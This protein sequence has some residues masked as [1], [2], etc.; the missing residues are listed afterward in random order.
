LANEKDWEWVKIDKKDC[1][2]FAQN[3]PNDIS[4]A[5]WMGGCKD[6]FNC[7]SIEGMVFKLTAPYLP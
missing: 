2:Y 5:I 6:G 3:T 1:K 7:L 4:H